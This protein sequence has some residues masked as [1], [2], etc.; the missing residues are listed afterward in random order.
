MSAR[1]YQD[2][3]SPGSHK[4][5]S[6]RISNRGRRCRA[7][8]DTVGWGVIGLCSLVAARFPESL[9]APIQARAAR[10]PQ[11]PEQLLERAR[12]L[13]NRKD[14]SGAARLYEQILRVDANSFEALSN[15]GVAEV[16][17]G[18]YTQAAQAYQRAL[19]LQPRSFPLL[20]NLGLC[21]FKAG[22]FKG[23]AKPLEQAVS[24]QP[25]NLQARSL[26]AMSYY[27]QREFE[28]ASRE[29]EKLIGAQPDNP[30]V[31]YL[32]DRKSTRL[33]SSHV[34]ISYAVFCLK[35]KKKKNTKIKHTNNYINK[36]N[37]TIISS[38]SSTSKPYKYTNVFII[39]NSLSALKSKY[40]SS[41][42]HV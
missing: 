27:S 26:L 32:L 38:I 23:A 9:C 5:L 7:A 33:N 15:L 19:S 11:R 20:L 12:Q 24:V 8:V 4:G 22:D 42:I 40:Q 37:Y 35:K 29:F 41:Y 34:S 39:S 17:L 31:Q 16:Q 2:G 18:K 3:A 21:Y 30:T 1:R 36:H 28:P 13:L 10:A 6:L 25:D 14:Y